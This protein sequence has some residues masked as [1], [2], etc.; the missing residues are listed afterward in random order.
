M[1]T[2]NAKRHQSVY[3]HAVEAVVEPALRHQLGVGALLGD[4]LLGQH[5]DELRAADGR[6]AVGDRKGPWS[7]SLALC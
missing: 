3:H 6:Q 4:P 1:E 7:R 5:E 2:C